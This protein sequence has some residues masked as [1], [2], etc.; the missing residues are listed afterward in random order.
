MQGWL[1]FVEGAVL[2]WLEQATSSASPAAGL[3]RTAL[4]GAVMAAAAGGAELK[5][6]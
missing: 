5:R 4:G 6:H 3:L 2:R 1:F